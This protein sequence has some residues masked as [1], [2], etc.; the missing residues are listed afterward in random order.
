[1]SPYLQEFPL[2][3][4]ATTREVAWLDWFWWV[5]PQIKIVYEGAD[6]TLGH[7]YTE[8]TEIV[9]KGMNMGLNPHVWRWKEWNLTAHAMMHRPSP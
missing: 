4:A 1:V 7:Y 5:E 8:I 9:Q 2:P 6:W 3:R